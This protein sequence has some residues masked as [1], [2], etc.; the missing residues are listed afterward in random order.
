MSEVTAC[1]FSGSYETGDYKFN[2]MHITHYGQGKE[3]YSS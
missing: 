2:G 3:K 1:V